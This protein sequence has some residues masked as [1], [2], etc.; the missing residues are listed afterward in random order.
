[1]VSTVAR[2]PTF[3]LKTFD[4]K[5]VEELPITRSAGELFELEEQIAAMVATIRGGRPSPCTGQDGK[6]SVA[7]CLATQLS[8]Q[9]GRRVAMKE[10]L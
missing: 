8:V 9:T 5:M 1:M 3:F 2:H 10:V 6:W 7:L 4:G